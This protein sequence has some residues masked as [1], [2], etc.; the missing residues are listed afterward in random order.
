MSTC[1]IEVVAFGQVMARPWEQTG[2][3]AVIKPNETCI[4]YCGCPI[5]SES[6]SDYTWDKVDVNAGDPY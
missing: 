5:C 4:C 1:Q 3:E 6:A 2:A